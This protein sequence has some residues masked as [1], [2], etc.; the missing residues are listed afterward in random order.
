MDDSSTNPANLPPAKPV[1]GVH[2]RCCNV[3]VHLHPNAAKDAF[4][5]FCPRCAAPVRV[6][7]VEQGGSS[8]R[9]FTT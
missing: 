5:G 9:I 3:Y 2:L 6:P 7:I 8:S 4:V 1:V